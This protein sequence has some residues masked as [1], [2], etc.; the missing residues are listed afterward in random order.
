MEENLFLF[1]LTWI[2]ILKFLNSLSPAWS[3]TLKEEMNPSG[4]TGE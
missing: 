1:N 3:S 4:L 2:K